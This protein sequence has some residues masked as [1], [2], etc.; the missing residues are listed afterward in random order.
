MLII[1]LVFLQV[2]I[3]AGMIFALQRIMTKNVVSATK[4]IEEMNQDYLK[5]EELVTRQLE[6]AKQQSQVMITNAKQE[7]EALKNKIVKDANTESEGLINDARAKG[8]EIIQQADKTRER[9]IQEIDEKV[10]L[11]AI[12]V[13][14]ELIHYTLPE[15]F[16]KDIHS[17]WVKELIESGFGKVER[18]NIPKDIKT[19]KVTSAFAL[20][21]DQRK[22]LAKKV[23][24]ILGHDAAMKEEVDPKIVAGIVFDIGSLILDGSLKN[25]I[26]EQAKNAK[27]AGRE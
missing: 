21:N 16:R 12:D 6:E 3:F 13:A 17:Q 22:S 14:T 23:K 9:L 27:H 10:A 18:L 5:K 24:S 4:H 19:V 11:A 8:T 26:R 7:A 2:L 20:D 1:S 15:N 25:K